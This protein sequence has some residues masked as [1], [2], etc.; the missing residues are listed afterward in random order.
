MILMSLWTW[1]EASAKNQDFKGQHTL[2]QQGQE[3]DHHLVEE[4]RLFGMTQAVCE[5]VF[6]RHVRLYQ[7]C[8]C[9]YRNSKFIGSRN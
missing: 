4:I 6:D 3:M 9:S 2:P 8:N 1:T 5:W 7:F